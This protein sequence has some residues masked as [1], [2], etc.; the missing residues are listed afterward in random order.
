M[1]WVA[2]DK[3]K[4]GQ[5]GSNPINFGASG[6]TLK[7][8]I[9]TSIYTPDQTNDEFITACNSNE[10]SGTNYSAGGPTLASKTLVVS[11]HTLTFGCATITIA[12]S[13]GGFSNGRTAVLYHDTGVA[14]TSRLVAYY[15]F[16]GSKGNV[17]G[18]LQLIDASGIFTV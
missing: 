15:D 16:G 11:G 18:D 8:M 12:Q 1:A 9:V 17:S 5:F 13:A 4:L 6:D 3:H 14:G 7:I 2:Y 10:V